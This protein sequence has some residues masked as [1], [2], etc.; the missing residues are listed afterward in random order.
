MERFAGIFGIKKPQP[1]DL[2]IA[3]L[4]FTISLYSVDDYSMTVAAL[5][6]TT[7]SPFWRLIS[8][9]IF[10]TYRCCTN[11]HYSEKSHC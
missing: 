11:S 1:L 8:F 9:V 2:G 6:D 10:Q 4:V 3:A 7:V 5:P